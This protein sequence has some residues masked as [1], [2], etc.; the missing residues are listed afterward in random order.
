MKLTVPDKFISQSWLKWFIEVLYQ[1]E[2]EKTS[3]HRFVKGDLEVRIFRAEKTYEVY[4]QGKRIAQDLDYIFPH[5]TKVLH[6]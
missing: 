1:N 5:L 6:P 2:F 3:P 4:Q